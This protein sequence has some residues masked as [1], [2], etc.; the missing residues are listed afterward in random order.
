MGT[1]AQR[2]GDR[3]RQPAVRRRSRGAARRGTPVRHHHRYL[4][5]TGRLGG[6][7][8][9][10]GAAGG[11]RSRDH[12]EHGQ[13]A[14]RRCAGS[15]RLGAP[16]QAHRHALVF[17][18]PARRLSLVSELDALQADAE[19]RLE[20]RDGAAAR[21]LRMP[22][23]VYNARVADKKQYAVEV[24]ARRRNTSPSS[25]TKPRADTSSL[26]PSRCATPAASRRSSSAATGSSPMR[27]AWYRRCAGLGVVGAQPLLEPG[28]SF[29]IHQRHGDRDRGRHDE[30]RLPDGRRR[31]HALRRAD[32]RIH[33]FSA[34]RASLI[35]V[36]PFLRPGKPDD[37]HR[38]TQREQ[39]FEVDNPHAERLS[40]AD[41]TDRRL[42]AACALPEV[43]AAEA[44]SR[45]R[46]IPGVHLRR[47][48]GLAERRARAQP[49]GVPRR[50]PAQRRPFA[51]VRSRGGGA[52]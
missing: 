39:D 16:A 12:H 36:L 18:K 43:S 10:R 5:R 37:E 26:T 44:G 8:R 49:A 40:S 35:V 46:A 23:G 50:L 41:C 2:A 1:A 6:P 42:R 20:R 15:A 29:E 14:L 22:R 13:R 47:A 28:Q 33:A 9:P 25:R 21:R 27:R 45:N 11:V 31:R 48:T 32:S 52:T 7:R 4:A 34:A 38:E 30:R 19:R 17:V 51:A 3:I 24:A